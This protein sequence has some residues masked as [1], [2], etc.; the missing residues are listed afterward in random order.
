MIPNIWANK[1]LKQMF[2]RAMDKSI[3]SYSMGYNAQFRLIKPHQ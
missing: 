3:R 1:K 2:L